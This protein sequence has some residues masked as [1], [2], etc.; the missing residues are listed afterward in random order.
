MLLDIEVQQDGRSVVIRLTGQVDGSVADW[1]RERI[2]PYLLPGRTVV[3]DLAD[4][5]FVDS[6][7][8]S[9]FVMCH[10]A[11]RV[12]GC[13]FWVEGARDEVAMVLE[14]TGLVELLSQ[15]AE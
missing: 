2:D 11:A 6:A 7:G 10:N 8:L 13:R 14:L 12:S 4:L 15:P 3:I 9:V 1:L 5:S